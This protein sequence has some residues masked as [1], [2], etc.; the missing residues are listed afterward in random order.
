MLVSVRSSRRA[1]SQADVALVMQN[2]GVWIDRGGTR[3]SKEKGWEYSCP[4]ASHWKFEISGIPAD[5]VNVFGIRAHGLG[6]PNTGRFFLA[7]TLGTL[8]GANLAY[9]THSTVVS[10][11]QPVKAIKAEDRGDQAVDPLG[12]GS[13]E[14]A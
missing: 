11:L 6:V 8:K 7:G 2:S 3:D 1:R 13:V 10:G 4:L 5:W 9:V 12:L 14:Y